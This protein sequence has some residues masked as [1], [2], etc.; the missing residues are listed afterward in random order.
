MV[1]LVT[2]T[3]LDSIQVFD[4]SINFAIHYI[5]R[6]ELVHCETYYF[7]FYTKIISI[8]ELLSS[9][10]SILNFSLTLK[11]INEIIYTK[12]TLIEEPLSSSQSILNFNLTLKKI[13]KNH[14]SYHL[15]MYSVAVLKTAQSSIMDHLRSEVGIDNLFRKSALMRC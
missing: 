1:S 9:S 12:I 4:I 5:W 11:K 14:C 3:L 7:C 10:K 2:S 6:K 15:V 8:E 13:Q